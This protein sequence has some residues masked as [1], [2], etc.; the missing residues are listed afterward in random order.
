MRA[1]TFTPMPDKV[2]VTD[3]DEGT[4]VTAGGIMIRDDQGHT[5]GIR[6]R[7]GQV[8]FIGEGVRDEIKIGDWVLVEHGRWTQRI[9]LDLGDK[10]LDVWMID[11]NAILAVSDENH[12]LARVTIS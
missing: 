11:Q 1:K 4:H 2:F 6:N 8:A 12:S 10:P 5:H 3:M 9:K 7:W